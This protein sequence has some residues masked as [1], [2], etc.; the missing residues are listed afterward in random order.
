[1]F[2]PLMKIFSNRALHTNDA[3]ER[4]K[5]KIEFEL[6]TREISFLN[7]FDQTGK[8]RRERGCY[9]VTLDADN[10][11]DREQFNRLFE[12]DQVKLDGVTPKQLAAF[13]VGFSEP[14]SIKILKDLAV[15]RKSL[16]AQVEA[17]DIASAEAA[18]M[19]AALNE[20]TDLSRTEPLFAEM[21][22]KQAGAE[23]AKAKLET[24]QRRIAE[25]EKM[26]R[27]SISQRRKGEAERFKAQLNPAAEA[28]NREIEEVYAKF[29]SVASEVLPLIAACESGFPAQIHYGSPIV[30]SGTGGRLKSLR[31][32]PQIL[33]RPDRLQ[34]ILKEIG[35]AK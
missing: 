31:T 35:P 7:S 8:F 11:Q 32:M 23:L 34:F 28:F 18:V 5:M 21:K 12:R 15:T 9:F 16:P 30:D 20:N 14:E 25:L 10:A 24:T 2:P 6:R 26:L 4:E 22:R 3:K 27:D 13:D 29:W 33:I 1:M 17:F 19:Q